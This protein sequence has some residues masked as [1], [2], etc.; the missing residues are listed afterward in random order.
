MAFG[1]GSGSGATFVG[2]V[3][4]EEVYDPV[5]DTEIDAQFLWQL[6][7]SFYRQLMEDREIFEVVWAGLIQDAAAELLTLWQ[8]DYA[9]SHR[10]IPVISQRKWQR[11]DFIQEISFV[12]DPELST[13][14]LLDIFVYDPDADVL[15]AS[16]VNRSGIDRAFVGLLASADEDTSLSW[17]VEVNI[18]A[19][20]AKGVMLFG[21]FNYT[22]PVLADA[23]VTG[24]IGDVTNADTPYAFIGHYS[25]LG[26][27]TLSVGSFVLSLD[28]DYRL[29]STYT[30]R[31]GTVVL[32]V[33]EIRNQKL[34]SSTGKTAEGEYG[35]VYTGTFMDTA[36]NFDT[37]GI[38]VGD[39]L[40]LD[41]VDY[42]ILSVDGNTLTVEPASLP[43]DAE[44]LSYEIQ[45]EVI[46]T[47]LSLDLPGDASDPTFTVNQFGT[48]N[49]DV[50]TIPPVLIPNPGEAN[51]KSLTATTKNW[52]YL[53]PTVSSVVL[54]VPRLQETI[55][56]PTFLAYEGTDYSVVSTLTGST[57]KFQDPPPEILWAE[58]AGY[59]EGQIADN[60][61]S[62]VNLVEIASDA[63]KA[64]V[65]GLYYA[66]F[67][68]PTMSAI[69]TGVH[70]LIGLPIAEK[71]GTV[72]SINLSY[73]GI[74]GQITVAGVDYYF[75]L[76]VGTS[77]SVGDEVSLF[78]PLSDGVEITD[79]IKDPYWWVNISSV[80]ELQ[81]VHTFAVVLNLDAFDLSTL[82]FAGEFVDTIK[83]TWKQALF[84]VQKN[85]EDDFEVDDDVTL[86]LTLHLYD[87]P[88]DAVLVSYD[89]NIFEGEEA[90]WKYSQGEDDWDAT[91]AAMR[92][93]STL[94]SGIS[95]FLNGN[96]AVTGTDTA[97][98]DEI[99]V[100]AVTDKY[101]SVAR[102][103][104]GTA[105][106]T[107][108]SSNVFR[109][110]TAGAFD[111]L[112]EGGIIEIDGEGSFEI[113][114]I[115]SP[116]QLIVDGTLLSDNTGV[117]W[118]ATGLQTI[119]GQVASTASQTSLTLSTNFGGADGDYKIYLLDVDYKKV[120]YD[121]FLEECMDEA[122]T[123]V[124]E[125]T[126]GTPGPYTV[127]DSDPSATT[128]NDFSVTNP[129]TVTLDEPTP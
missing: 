44:D 45:G 61:G 89:D 79:Y 97:Y 109:D 30:A 54:S 8:N 106:E 11:F 48:S 25:N 22:Q 28:T 29:D 33:V 71:A 3:V 36:V 6:L 42:E 117:A 87:V 95:A 59:D 12:N 83:P 38:V 73:S 63:Y 31:T 122:F 66:Y 50:R 77:L 86:R 120:F 57:F 113:Q 85:L 124:I 126:G 43:V 1:I 17:S 41:S 67:Q 24:V 84:I 74:L 58:Y 100:G 19:V 10:D 34:T 26:D 121:Q 112:E 53:E 123:I 46:V 51:R 15:G 13:Q 118:E 27:A 129:Y 2:S 72:E 80:H 52:E 98:E 64:K 104:T 70:I 47:S 49:M 116:N 91:S 81:K 88:C 78:Q 115:T 62:L 92:Q 32:N 16:W 20:D 56:D 39:I 9:K 82:A 65:R 107:F 7:P 75:P 40:V 18:S 119:W 14:G 69:R 101:V 68:G 114:A 111:D 60:F 110:M 5:F 4:A 90:D 125:Q 37:E 105:G 76:L 128:S 127:P 103:V 55:T 102:Y 21:Y 23:L 99:G 94:L 96:T 93:T 108:A 35:D